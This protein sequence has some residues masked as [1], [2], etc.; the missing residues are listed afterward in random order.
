MKKG[1]IVIFGETMP[2]GVLTYDKNKN[3]ICL[4]KG[5][6]FS[7]IYIRKLSILK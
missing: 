7:K 3:K 5:L 1:D 2:D 6:K 4:Q